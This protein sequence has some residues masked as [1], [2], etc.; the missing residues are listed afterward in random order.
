ML[1]VDDVVHHVTLFGP[2]L[3]VLFVNCMTI[4]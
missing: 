4:D 3:P 2:G 1:M